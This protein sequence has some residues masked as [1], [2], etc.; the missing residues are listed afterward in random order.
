MTCI[1]MHVHTLSWSTIAFLDWIE[2]NY[3]YTMMINLH[4]LQL[5]SII[6]IL[7]R[8]FIILIYNTLLEYNCIPRLD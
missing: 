3:V 5:S 2:S 7:A 6:N 1:Y 4:R 8:I